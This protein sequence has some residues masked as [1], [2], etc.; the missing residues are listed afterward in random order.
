MGS[1]WH[2]FNHIKPTKNGKPYR[3]TDRG[4]LSYFCMANCDVLFTLC[5]AEEVQRKGVDVVQKGTWIQRKA[6][7]LVQGLFFNRINR[8]DVKPNPEKSCLSAHKWGTNGLIC[9]MLL[10]KMLRKP[11]ILAWNPTK[12]LL[13]LIRDSL[14]L[15]E[16]SFVNLQFGNWGFY[17]SSMIMSSPNCYSLTGCLIG[18]H[19]FGADDFLGETPQVTKRLDCSRGYMISPFSDWYLRLAIASSLLHKS[20][21]LGFQFAGQVDHQIQLQNLHSFLVYTCIS[22]CQHELGSSFSTLP[23]MASWPI[24]TS[25]NKYEATCY[26]HGD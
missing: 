9:G 6:H 18:W 20:H 10:N 24:G 7:N 17:S 23:D 4:F 8:V 19:H 16:G 13:S 11:C 3:T 14:W 15:S 21:R 1:L 26:F 22:L 25:R 12:F 5:S 2:C